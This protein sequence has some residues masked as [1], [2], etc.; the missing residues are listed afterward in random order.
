MKM[1]RKGFT[2][3]E[4]MTVMAIMAIIFA[5]AMPKI[6]STRQS[7]NLHSARDQVA[8]ALATAKAAAVQ[9][10]RGA[11]FHISGNTMYVQADTNSAGLQATVL[12]SI[13]L[14]TRFGVTITLRDQRDTMISFDPRGVGSTGSN[15][16]ARIILVGATASDSVCVSKMGVIMRSG[17]AL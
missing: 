15:G 3:M 10:G 8:T 9:K 4:M 6:T 12:R 2:V 16:T 17:C 14:N 7:A 11:Q 13:P 1:R 5:M